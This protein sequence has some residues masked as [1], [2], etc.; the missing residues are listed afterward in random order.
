MK[1]LFPVCLILIVAA[2]DALHAAPAR[3]LYEPASPPEMPPF[4]I[5]FRGTQWFGKTY[6]GTDWHITFE[7]SGGI[8]N[9]ENG[10]TYRVGSWKATGP[11]SVHMEL[12]NNYYHYRGTVVGDTLAGDSSNVNGLRWKTT[13]RRVASASSK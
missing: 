11:V 2:V 12:N 1:R 8:T 6:E 7:P 3:M 10:Q 9:I 4:T 13:F 5:D